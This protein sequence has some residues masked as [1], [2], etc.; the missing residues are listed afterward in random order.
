LMSETQEAVVYQR[1]RLDLPSA[2]QTSLLR[3]LCF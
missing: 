1:V 3:E 2:H